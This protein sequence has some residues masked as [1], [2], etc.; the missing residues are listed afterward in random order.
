MLSHVIQR[1]LRPRRFAP[2]TAELDGNP[3]PTLFVRRRG[4]ELLGESPPQSPVRDLNF[5]GS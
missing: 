4:H 3:P 2:E 5:R 1:D